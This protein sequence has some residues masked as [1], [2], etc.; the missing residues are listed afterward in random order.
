MTDEAFLDGLRDRVGAA[1][2]QQ[3]LENRT[4]CEVL[5]WVAPVYKHVPPHP[6][7]DRTLPVIAR[8]LRSHNPDQNQLYRA[9]KESGMTSPE[10]S[11]LRQ[12]LEVFAGLALRHGTNTRRLS[13][14]LGKAIHCD[15]CLRAL[16]IQTLSSIVFDRPFSSELCDE[17][18]HSPPAASSE[19]YEALIQQVQAT[20]VDEIA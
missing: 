12:S 17:L 14:E 10:L 18:G 8:C 3:H 16:S 13:E 2:G 20:Y 1:R 19:L 6:L 11:N 9:F 5:S 4:S 15:G 7:L